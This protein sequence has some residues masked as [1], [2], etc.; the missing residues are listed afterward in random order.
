M[1]LN[2]SDAR[3]IIL[4]MKKQ[5]VA[6]FK[7]DNLEIKFSTLAFADDIKQFGQ[8]TPKK[9]ENEEEELLYASAD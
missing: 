1:T 6:E 5:K 3:K 9:E 2:F 8:T 7:I 4:W